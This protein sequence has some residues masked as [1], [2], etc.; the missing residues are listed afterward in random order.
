MNRSTNLRADL[1]DYSSDEE[2][3]MQERIDMIK[4]AHASRKAVGA[5]YDN[6]VD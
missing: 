5:Y 6:T 4:N 2:Q 3:R 1:L